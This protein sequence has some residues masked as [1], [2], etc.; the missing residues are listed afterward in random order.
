MAL[1]AGYLKPLT[2]RR[3]TNDVGVRIL[4]RTGATPRPSPVGYGSATWLIDI[5]SGTIKLASF[6]SALSATW[7]D[8]KSGGYAASAGLATSAVH[9]GSATYAASAGHANSATAANSAAFAASAAYA[10]SA[11]AHN[12]AGAQHSADTLANLNTKISDATLMDSIDEDDMSSDSATKV[13]TQ[14][15][16][17]KYVDDNAGDSSVWDADLSG[18][19]D[20]QANGDGSQDPTSLIYAYGDVTDATTL[21]VGSNVISFELA[22]SGAD[23]QVHLYR[24]L[25]AE[26]LPDL[27]EAG[28]IVITADIDM[29]NLDAN[30]DTISFRVRNVTSGGGG[31]TENISGALYNNAG[32]V[33]LLTGREVNNAGASG[34][35]NVAAT[36]WSNAGQFRVVDIVGHQ[37]CQFY[38]SV[39]NNLS[40]SA[41]LTQ[42]TMHCREGDATAPH[43]YIWIRAKDGGQVK[44]TISNIKVTIY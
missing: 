27:H 7:E 28:Q 2:G 5:T 24:A 33:R 38:D 9:A 39:A 4:A 25:S 12:L 17:K 26:G 1:F 11:P 15:S 20:W 34:A 36:N 32:T 10:A 8:V 37:E 31:D 42:T 22:G 30:D 44:G 19:Y 21:E 29:D 18:T 43:L 35:G 41:G 40:E 3:D 16:V 13:P 23:K 14:Q 6:T